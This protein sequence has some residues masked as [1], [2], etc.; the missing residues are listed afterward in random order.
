MYMLGFSLDNLSLMALTIA[1][2]FVVDDA[3]VMLENIYRHIEEGEKPFEAAHQGCGRDRLHDRLDQP[4][5]GRGVHS[6]AA[7]GRHC[8]SAVPG[9]RADRHR[10]RLL[11][12]PIVSLTLTPMMCSRFLKTGGAQARLAVPGQSR[13]YSMP[14]WR[15]IERTLEH[16]AALAVPHADERSSPPSR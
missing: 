3:I 15:S 5:T 11:V 2:G 13:P 14:C 9:I 1:V 8:R 6:A 10:S 16:R 4:V 12:S 7:H